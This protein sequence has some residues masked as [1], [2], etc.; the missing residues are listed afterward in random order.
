MDMALNDLKQT[1]TDEF[2]NKQREFEKLRSSFEDL[3]IQLNQT[4]STLKSREGEIASYRDAI[5]DKTVVIDR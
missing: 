4:Q 5:A 1:M 2:G 3:M